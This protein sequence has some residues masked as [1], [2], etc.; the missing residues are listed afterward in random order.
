MRPGS[1]GIF[2]KTSVVSAR[3]SLLLCCLLLVAAE[4]GAQVRAPEAFFGFRMG[5]D[6]RL[7]SWP[8]IVRY[9]EEVAAGSD[10]VELVDLGPTTDGNRTMAAIV[11][12]AANIKVARQYSGCQ[13]APVGSRRCLQPQARKT[14]GHPEGDRG[15]RRRHSRL[16]GGRAAGAE[17]DAAHAGHIHRSGRAQRAATRSSSSLFPCSTRTVTGW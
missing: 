11:S 13:P 16:G 3:V 5:A 9:F 4:A 10:R 7:A 2:N 1:F 8:D 12:S 15:H 14:R 17:R 6:G